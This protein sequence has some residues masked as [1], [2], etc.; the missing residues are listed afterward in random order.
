MDILNA[1][2][3][4]V[5]GELVF[6][7]QEA[8]IRLSDS[9]GAAQASEFASLVRKGCADH[10]QANS[11]EAHCLIKFALDTQQYWHENQGKRKTEGKTNV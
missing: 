5:I 6:A 8:A 4:R 3:E 9:N 7:L 1:M 11:P 2:T 10:G